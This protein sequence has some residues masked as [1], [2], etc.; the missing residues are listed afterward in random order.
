MAQKPS[1][2]VQHRNH[3]A[4]KI[5]RDV[6]IAEQMVCNLMTSHNPERCVRNLSPRVHKEQLCSQFSGYIFHTTR[7]HKRRCLPQGLCKHPITFKLDMN[8][9]NICTS[10][11]YM[12]LRN[13]CENTDKLFQVEKASNEQMWQQHNGIVPQEDDISNFPGKGRLPSRV[14]I[15]Y[16]LFLALIYF[17]MALQFSCFTIVHISH[18]VHLFSLPCLIEEI[19]MFSIQQKQVVHLL[20]A[21]TLLQFEIHQPQDCKRLTCDDYFF[22][23]NTTASPYLKEESSTKGI[24]RPN[25]ALKQILGVS[26]SLLQLHFF[27]HLIPI[28]KEKLKKCLSTKVSQTRRW[29]YK[30][31]H[32]SPTSNR[33]F[34][35]TYQKSRKFMIVKLFLGQVIRKEQHA[36]ILSASLPQLVQQ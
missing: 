4:K 20:E 33:R 29:V 26:E 8:K 3:Q 17:H 28:F 25:P 35:P 12:D 30:V 32:P 2:L 34:S 10:A 21:Q 11:K 1:M 24:L 7:H 15:I 19:D 31:A 23:P 13:R 36:R 27:L 5:V 16:S 22:F 6:A 14:L 18:D 9:S